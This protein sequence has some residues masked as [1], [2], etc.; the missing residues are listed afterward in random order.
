MRYNS[1]NA[2]AGRREKHPG[3]TVI[4]KTV[5]QESWPPQQAPAFH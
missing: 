2:N 1:F 4:A 5:W 3:D